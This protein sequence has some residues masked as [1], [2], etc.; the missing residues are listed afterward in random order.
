MDYHTEVLWHHFDEHIPAIFHHICSI[1][2]MNQHSSLSL[3]LKKKLLY[4][5]L[6]N[7]RPNFMVQSEKQRSLNEM[8]S[9]WKTWCGETSTSFYCICTTWEDTTDI[10]FL[11][12]STCG[13]QILFK[14]YNFPTK[15]FQDYQTKLMTLF[16][17]DLS[18]IYPHH[19]Q[20]N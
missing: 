15:L 4:N 1:P 10:S 12:C 17:I 18:Q 2:L 20:C 7:S 19:W 11:Y 14:M 8:V 16:K 5:I 13:S 6:R 9:L 3:K